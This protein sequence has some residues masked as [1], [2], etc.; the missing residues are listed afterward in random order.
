MSAA[1]PLSLER[2]S[3]SSEDDEDP[4]IMYAAV[5]KGSVILARFT[6]FDGNFED[7]VDHVLNRLG[8]SDRELTLL[9]EGDQ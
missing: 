4:K 3:E 6:P 8:P 9:A 2:D 5:A 7:V 1:D